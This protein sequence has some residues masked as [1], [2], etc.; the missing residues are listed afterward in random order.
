MSN[1]TG[2]PDNTEKAAGNRRLPVRRLN[3]HPVQVQD[4]DGKPLNPC[5]PARARELLRKNRA[6]RVSRYPFTIR[7]LS[8][9]QA[10]SRQRVLEQEAT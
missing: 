1:R 6:V 10:D 2:I 4:P 8:Q 9:D 5:H 3:H 7:L